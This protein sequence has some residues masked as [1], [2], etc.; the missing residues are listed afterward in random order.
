MFDARLR[1]LIDP[2]LNRAGQWLAARGV[3]ANQLT[4]LGILAGLAAAGAIFLGQFAAAIALILAS[5]LLDGLDGA[6]ARATAKTPFGGYLDIVGDFLFYVS[7]PL[8]F[9]LADPA[10]LKPAMLLLASFAL[11]GVS[12]LAFASIAAEQRLET[13]AHGEKSFFYSTGIAEGGETILAFLLMVLFP[14]HFP[15]IAWGF[16]ALCCLTV[17]QRSWLAWRI[18]RRGA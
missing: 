8:A 6:V 7:V 9:G 3:T 1:P 15:A 14:A 18:F 16:A 13:R 5:R 12:F 4:A 11:T 10:N 17:V 2:P